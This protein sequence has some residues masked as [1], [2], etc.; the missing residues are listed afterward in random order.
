MGS[1]KSSVS[2]NWASYNITNA[3]PV[4]AFQFNKAS[5]D[6]PNSP[7]SGSFKVGA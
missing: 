5:G 3:L 7:F 2:D 1:E 6:K 4:T